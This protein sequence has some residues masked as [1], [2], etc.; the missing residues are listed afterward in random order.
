[1]NNAVIICCDNKYVSK[2]IV[3]LKQFSSYN[4]GYK[5]V[6]I[7]TQFS[8]EMKSLCSEYNIEVIEI[9]LE[10][11]FIDLDKRLYGKRY[12]IECFY[13]FYAYKVLDNYDYII[14]IEPDICTNKKIN[15]DFET[16]P[17][18]GGSY[19]NNLLIKNFYP[20]MNKYDILKKVYGDGN[21]N[22]HRIIGGV[23]I[24]NVT[25]LKSI[26]FYDQIVKYY[27]KCLKINNQRCGDDSLMV[28]YQ[29]FNPSH[30]KLL[31]PNFHVILIKKNKLTNYHEDI[32]FFHNSAPKY[33]KVNN[34][35]KLS[36]SVRYCYD[37]MIEY[38]YNN[39]SINFIKTYLS[40]IY[41]DINDLKIPFYYYN[42]N[43]NFGDLITPYYL[44][45][46]C[47][48]DGFSYDFST[49]NSKII[50]CGSIMRLCHDNV[51]VYGSGIRDID[52]NIKKGIIKIVRGPLTRNR[53]LKIN[54]YCPPIFGDPGLLLPIYY[55]PIIDK[56]YKLGII[57]HHI[58]YAKVK[59]M[60]EES[61]DVLVINL[62]NKNIELVI[63][64][65]L[66]CCKTISSSLHGLII[67]DAYN[68]PNK[69]VKF[70][71]G[72]NGDDT[73]YYDYFM[74]VNRSDTTY[75]DCMNYKNIPNDVLNIIDNVDITFDFTKLKEQMFFD[76]NGLKNYTKY[77]YKKMITRN[78]IVNKIKWLAFKSHWKLTDKNY[79]LSIQ[80]T[81]L[82]KNENHNSKLDIKD[83][84]KIFK[85]HRVKL[86][87]NA[88]KHYYYVSFD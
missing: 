74:S 45:K 24:Y 88:N 75:I 25:G 83:K 47:K 41:I 1:M 35:F 55:Y 49:D 14:K 65:I 40:E 69:W 85:N 27:T 21:M 81:Y 38:I 39:F 82:K 3:A 10:E 15:I 50:S 2:G 54:C 79:I 59:K 52:Q 43:D 70:N 7:G 34:M 12:P 62:I 87:K 32:T 63:N 64:D 67:S 57:P 11:D 16:I 23:V 86:I 68:I 30:I 58:H 26:N 19:V 6:I 80:D 60:Y 56:K 20:I 66:S 71:N 9:N 13:H 36:H 18:I 61:E 29:L 33:W 5:E 42:G 8:D 51:I 4:I 77:L 44:K 22:Q 73:K 78:V 46:F 48:S 84:I 17:Y 72:V 37:M 28:M 31:N 53:L 76:E